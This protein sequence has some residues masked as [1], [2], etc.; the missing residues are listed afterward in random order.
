[1]IPQTSELDKIARLIKQAPF[2]TVEDTVRRAAGIIRASEGSATVVLRNGAIAGIV[3]ESDIAG[4]LANASD[5]EAALNQ[6][7]ESIVD[8][9]PVFVSASATLRDVA[10]A[11]ASTGRDVLPVIG[12]HG[13]YQGVIYRRDVVGILTRNLRPPTLA[14]M[15]TPLGVYLTTGAHSGGAGYLGL[16][17]SGVSLMLMI[18]LAWLIVT[19]LQSVFQAI[20]KIPL[21]VFLQSPPLTAAFHTNDLSLY[22]ATGLSVLFMLILLRLSPLS[23]YHAAEHMTVHAIE[24]GEDLTP[25][26]VSR[27][28]RV[29]PRCGTNLLAAVGV[30]VIITTKVSNQFAVLVALIIVLMGWRSIG[31][32]LQYFFTTSRP[33]RKQLENGIAAGVEVIERYQQSPNRHSR[34]FERIWNMGFLQV[35]SGMAFVGMLGVILKDYAHIAWLGNLGF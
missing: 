19:G 14:G 26:N 30:F 32:W 28:P 9:S 6:P 24:A 21:N 35:A 18:S 17:L 4:L 8:G 12:E 1:M 22:V 25:E 10:N 31:G 11:L 5:L 23:G 34:G 3:S 16:F 7:I 13:A 15:A 29:H 33:S 20:T 27:M 2:L